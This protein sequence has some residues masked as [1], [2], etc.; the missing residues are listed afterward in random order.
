[1]QSRPSS[2]GA[3]A[4][5]DVVTIRPADAL[6]ATTSPRHVRHFMGLLLLRFETAGAINVPNGG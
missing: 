3:K 2:G 5:F 1:M 6:I 4:A